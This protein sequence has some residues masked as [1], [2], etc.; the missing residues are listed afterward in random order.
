MIVFVSQKGCNILVAT[1]GRLKQFVREGLVDLSKVKFF[2][3]D[4]ADRMLDM[5]FMP[6]VEE[7]VEKLPPKVTITIHHSFDNLF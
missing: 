3:L 1:T 5:G 4:E 6:D 7:I 2:I